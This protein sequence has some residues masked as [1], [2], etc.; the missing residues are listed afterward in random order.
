MSRMS[1]DHLST[2]I[3]NAYDVNMMRKTFEKKMSADCL[4]DIE[5]LREEAR[6]S[7]AAPVHGHEE[8]FSKFFF[9]S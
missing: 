3:D 4:N 5:E 7:Q 8:K 6:P 2:L 9:T 1:G